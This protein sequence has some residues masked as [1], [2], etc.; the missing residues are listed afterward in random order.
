MTPPLPAEGA[1]TRSR[2]LRRFDDA[3]ALEKGP[4]LAGVDE[5]GRGPLAGPVTAA[6]V[7]LPPGCY[8][9]GVY[10][11]KAL[12]P[13][14]RSALAEE[15]KKQA[16][17]WQLGWCWQDRIDQINILQATKEAM[18]LAVRGLTC[19]PDHL[20]LDALELPD[21]ALPQT[22]LIK[23]DQ[24]S[25]HIAAASI[26]AKVARDDL[27]KDYHRRYPGYAFDK[28]KGYGTQAHYEGL[29]RL[30]PCPLHRMSF[31]RN[32]LER[33]KETGHG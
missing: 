31:L 22:A 20:L 3:F 10:D 24:C 13:G 12:S 2:A 21:L 17:A 18:M 23:G 9:E 19:Q 28:N 15:I 11:S 26:L 16:L 30:G 1:G 33:K 5:A 6:A 4:L 7:V 25:F 29:D 8:I 27:M 32:Y 14:R